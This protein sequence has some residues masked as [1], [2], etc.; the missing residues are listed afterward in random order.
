MQHYSVHEYVGC[1]KFGQVYC[2]THKATG[3]WV[4][5]KQETTPTILKHETQV[6]YYLYRNRCTHIPWVYWYG[7]VHHKPTLIMTWMNQ[8][9]LRNGRYDKSRLIHYWRELLDALQYIHSVDIVHRDIKP[10]NCMI[11]DGMVYLVDFGLATTVPEED[12]VTDHILGTPSYISLHIHDGHT[13]TKRDDLISLGY[14]FDDVLYNISLS[15]RMVVADE[16]NVGLVSIHHS[17]NK[18]ISDEKRKW[19]WNEYLK[20]CY[21]LGFFDVPD[22]RLLHCKIE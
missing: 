9:S 18:R 21:S 19:P 1:G 13:P 14:T 5:I 15:E 20:I 17:Q 12:V 16:N 4:A 11:R 22:Y 10:D 7:T 2:G 3:E 6:L 8:G